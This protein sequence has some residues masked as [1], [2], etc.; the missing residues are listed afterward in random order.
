MKF[1]LQ[2]MGQGQRLFYTFLEKETVRKAKEV[3]KDEYVK[4]IMFDS[5]SFIHS[6]GERLLE[7]ND[8]TMLLIINEI[9]NIKISLSKVNHEVREREPSFVFQPF[10]KNK[11][12]YTFGYNEEYISKYSFGSVDCLDIDKI[13]IKINRCEMPKT[14]DNDVWLTNVFFI[15]S[16]HYDGQEIAHLSYVSRPVSH[17]F[18]GPKVI[19]F[20]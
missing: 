2:I 18:I 19:D 20:E 12:M 7:Q 6:A 11:M 8:T 16:V 1:D 13:F 3:G 5:D 9:E 15:E 10:I 14:I 17:K 4:H